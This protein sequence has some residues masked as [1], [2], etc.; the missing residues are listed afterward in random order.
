MAPAV[1]NKVNIPPDIASYMSAIQFAEAR[2]GE[3]YL[4]RWTP[5]HRRMVY[6]WKSGQSIFGNVHHNFS[7]NL[8]F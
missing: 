2:S 3:K 5:S 8:F 4:W 1:P 6:L 7:T